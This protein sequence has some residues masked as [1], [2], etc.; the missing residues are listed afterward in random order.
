VVASAES[1][2]GR[3]ELRRRGAAEMVI[4]VGGRV[5]MSSA[6][7]RSESALAELACRRIAARPRPRVLLGGLGMG[8]TLRAALDGLPPGARVTVVEIEPAIVEW[9][10]GLLADLTDRALAD[11][12]VAVEIGDV[13]AAIG[14]SGAPAGKP[15]PIAGGPDGAGGSRAG[16]H[17]D[18]ILL[19]LF[20]GPRTRTPGQGAGDPLYGRAALARARAALAAGGVLAVW[21]EEPDAG[22]EARLA[23]A[24]FAWE[25]HRPG[26][27]GP[28]HAIYLATAPAAEPDRASHANTAIERA[29]RVTAAT[30]QRA[31][32]VTS[33]IDQRA[34]R[35]NAAIDQATRVTAGLP[36]TSRAGRGRP[37]RRR[38]RQ[39]PP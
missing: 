23:A 20:E 1:S 7:H 39:A 34:S 22:F 14:R 12:R 11:P 27:G 38:R 26:R 5:L 36:Q 3:L 24:G 21:S 32:R 15:A 16:A 2:E 29:S 35:F 33:A 13:A 37:A 10:R 8:Y 6:A 30:D 31:S 9:C 19:D 17:F 28:R 4:T 25:R 18:A